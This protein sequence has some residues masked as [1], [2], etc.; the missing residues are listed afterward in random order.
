MLRRPAPVWYINQNTVI[1]RHYLCL[2]FPSHLFYSPF[3]YL[4]SHIIAQ[5]RSDKVGS[6]PSS[7]TTVVALHFYRENITALFSVANSR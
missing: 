6:S 1:Q 2:V 4:S 3:V 7:S 5:I